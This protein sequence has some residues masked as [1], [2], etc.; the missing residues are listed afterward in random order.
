[1]GGSDTASIRSGGSSM[2]AA[3]LHAVRNGA[4]RVS[5]IP[6]EMVTTQDDLMSQLKPSWDLGYSNG[7]GS[8]KDF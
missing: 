7:K 8:S 2:S 3:K 1:M 6:K 5:R 4:Y